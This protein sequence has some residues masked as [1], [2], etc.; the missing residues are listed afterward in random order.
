MNMITDYD[1]FFHAI[2]TKIHIRLIFHETHI[3][4]TF[5]HLNSIFQTHL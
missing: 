4:Q 1:K 5:W 3:F 2:V